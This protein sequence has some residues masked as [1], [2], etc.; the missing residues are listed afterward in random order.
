MQNEQSKMYNSIM[1][2]L[3]VS[4]LAFVLLINAVFVSAQSPDRTKPPV[5]G[6]TPSLKVNTL[7][8]FTLTNGL[9]VVV[10]EKKEVPI[11]QLNLV[12]KAGSV[13]ETSDKLGLSG[14][15]ANMMDEGAAGKSSLELSDEVDFLGADI[16]ATGGLHNSAVTLRSTVSKFDSALKLFS[17]IL[18]R[19]DFPVNELERLKKQYITSLFQGF[20][21]PR[22]IAAA[23]TSLLVYGKEHQ[24]GR[25]TVGNENTINSLT[26]DDLKNFYSMYYRP[27]NAFLVVVGDVNA[28]EIIVKLESALAGWQKGEVLSVSISKP[29]QVDGRTIYLI[30]KPEA[31][32]S[33]IRICRIGVD[34]KSD[35]YFPILVMNTI[36]GGSFT[37]RLNSNLREKNGYAYGANSGFSMRPLPGPFIAASDVQTDKT[38]KALQEFM[39]ELTAIAKPVADEELT[40]AKNFVALGYPDN[41]SSVGSIAYQIGEMIDYNL[42]ES[43]FNDYIG[44]ILAVTKDDVRRVAKKYIDTDDLVIIVVGDKTKVEKGLKESKIGKM[45]NLTP[46]DVLGPMPKL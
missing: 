8:K 39:K 7:Q 28:K 2:F 9:Q 26:V 45:I 22:V 41:F 23:A 13:N 31:A 36:L 42:P 37:S 35:D 6:P 15:T 19:P 38:D 1:N 17:D 30:D 10:Y 43:Y 29:K 40:K 21:Q 24:Y 34:R 4:F 11:I 12:I 20:D 33:V 32:Q 18:L 16:G 27:N 3:R 44:K 46:T 5:L 14:M 25:T